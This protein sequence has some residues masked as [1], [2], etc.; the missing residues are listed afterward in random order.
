MGFQS[1]SALKS[2][3]TRK[4]MQDTQVWFLGWEDPL[5]EGMAMH[6]SIL[7]WKITRQST[8]SGYIPWGR[9]ELDPT[10]HARVACAHTHKHKQTQQQ[11]IMILFQGWKQSI[12][13]KG[14]VF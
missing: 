9:K 13:R 5:D 11:Y 1:D 4:E 2:S 3:S 14:C 10:E 7:A 12:L 6:S 8:L